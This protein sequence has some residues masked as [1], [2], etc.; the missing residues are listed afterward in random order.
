MD[1]GSSQNIV[2]AEIASAIASN[3][4]DSD[5]AVST[6]LAS[7]MVSMQSFCTSDPATWRQLSSVDR[8]SIVRKGPPKMP[9]SFP[10]D[11]KGRMFP[12]SIFAKTLPN[13]ETV[14]RDWL[15]WSQSKHALFC[16]PCCLFNKH[17]TSEHYQVQES[18]SKLARPNAGM[19]DNWRKLY[20]KIHSH[21]CNSAHLSH[22]CD[23]KALEKSLQKCTGIDSALQK[24]IVEQISQWREIL[25]WRLDIV[26]FLA[27]HNLSFRGHSS[28]IGDPDNGLFMSALELLSKHNRVLALH[29]QKVKM[30]QEEGCS[31]MQAHYLSWGSQNE[32]IQICAQ[33]VKNKIIE[34]VTNA[35]Y[36]GII[37]DG[38]PDASHTEQITFILRYVYY[39]DH[40]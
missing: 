16:F 1:E 34:E 35:I 30:H 29:L 39:I 7:N 15:V 5:S 28:K 3:S 12:D 33:L 20:T 13:G 21:E 25:K 19:T 22:Y 11:T 18:L 40:C 2:T 17:S 26:F 14:S 23:W 6:S 37:V 10:Y 9:S 31:R 38:T 32:F 36:Y 24:Q 27:E 8:E 4:D